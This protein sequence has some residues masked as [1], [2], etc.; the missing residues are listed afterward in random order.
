[1]DA[2]IAVFAY[3]TQL[4]LSLRAR[5]EEQTIDLCVAML[6]GYLCIG[7]TIIGG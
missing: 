2:D 4:L 6:L 5:P 1:M 3:A 7:S